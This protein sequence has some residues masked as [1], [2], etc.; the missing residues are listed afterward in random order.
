M[1]K[2]SLYILLILIFLGFSKSFS[3]NLKNINFI[4]DE[5]MFSRFIKDGPLSLIL[6]ES[7]EHGTFIKSYF[8]KYRVV[9]GFKPLKNQFI[10]FRTSKNFWEKG[11][12]NVGM[13]LYRTEKA[14]TPG[15]SVPMPPGF[16]FVGDLAYGNWQTKNNSK[17]WTFQRSYAH[18][19]K[20]FKWGS[21]IP[22]KKFFLKAVDHKKKGLPFYG[23]KNQFKK[24][25][26]SQKALSENETSIHK[27]L[28]YLKS[29]WLFPQKREK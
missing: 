24:T 13:S 22:N 3:P 4:K 15:N 26:S 19:P 8:Q 14:N 17:V 6:I 20:L 23:E 7:Y 28:K 25:H 2:I 5:K 29:Y 12:M 9:H 10:I 21:F 27:I 1:N 18:F 16:L 11:K